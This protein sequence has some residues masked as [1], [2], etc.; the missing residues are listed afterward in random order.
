MSYDVSCVT[1]RHFNLYRVFISCCK[2]WLWAL[3]VFPPSSLL[4][5]VNEYSSKISSAQTLL[6]CCLSVAG[7]SSHHHNPLAVAINHDASHRGSCGRISLPRSPSRSGR[8]LLFAEI[9]TIWIIL[10]FMNYS[11]FKPRHM[12]NRQSLTVI[13]S[14]VALVNM[15]IQLKEPLEDT[16]ACLVWPLNNTSTHKSKTAPNFK[17]SWGILLSYT[18]AVIGFLHKSCTTGCFFMPKVQW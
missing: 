17:L 5:F 3:Q 15:H 18:D 10:R 16:N 13:Q 7:G 4:G 2:V 14:Q 8:F 11:A 6:M 12:I 9:P 1:T